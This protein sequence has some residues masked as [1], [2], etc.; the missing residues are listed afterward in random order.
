M[1][2]KIQ[3]CKYYLDKQNCFECKEGYIATAIKGKQTICLDISEQNCQKFESA[4]AI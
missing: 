2:G 3:N 4:Q 1:E